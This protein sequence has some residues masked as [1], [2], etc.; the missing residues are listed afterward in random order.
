VLWLQQ[1]AGNGAT[2]R[3]LQVQRHPVGTAL[4]DKDQLVDTLA[5]APQIDPRAKEQAAA[6]AAAKAFNAGGK[7]KAMSLGAGES[8]LQGAY[9]GLAKIVPGNIELLD[10]REALWKRYDEV[11]IAKGVVNDSTGKP[12]AP[13][14]AKVEQPG[15]EGFADNGVVYVNKKTPLVTATAHEI[16]HNNAAPNF[17]HGVGEAINEGSTE[18]MAKKALKDAGV[19][20]PAGAAKAYPV[21]VAI[22]EALIGLVGEQTLIAAYFAGP[23]NL[24]AAYEKEKGADMW[25]AFVELAEA[26]DIETIKSFL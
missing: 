3:A 2:S 21:E 18:Y 14:D 8:I 13:G 24:K 7:N 20:T 1:R 23:K 16:L 9:G 15:I 19:V 12:W 25:S 4:A 17:R 5:A 26:L 11:S 22:V 6:Q 10:G